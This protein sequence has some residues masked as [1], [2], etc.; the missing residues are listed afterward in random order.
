MIRLP[1]GQVVDE[2]TIPNHLRPSGR[3]VY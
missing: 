1:T 2:A 3:Q